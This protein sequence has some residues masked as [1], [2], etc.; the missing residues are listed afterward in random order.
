[1]NESIIKTVSNYYKKL[2]SSIAL[3]LTILPFDDTNRYVTLDSA[4]CLD[5]IG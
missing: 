2:G 4:H 3:R 5:I 1:M